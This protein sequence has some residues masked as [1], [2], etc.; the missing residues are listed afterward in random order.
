MPW[1]AGVRYLLSMP[2][3]MLTGTVLVCIPY[4]YVLPPSCMSPSCMSSRPS[5]KVRTTCLCNG[6]FHPDRRQF[7]A[8]P[9]PSC[10]GLRGEATA[11]SRRPMLAS[12]RPLP[13]SLSP[14]HCS[15][16]RPPLLIACAS[17]Y[18]DLTYGA[19]TLSV[20]AYILPE[21]CPARLQ[22]AL[23]AHFTCACICPRALWS[24]T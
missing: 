5:R 16:H 15:W 12:L 14:S 9:S 1:R 11:S 20:G 2:V 17:K 18:S 19:L 10:G 13:P 23:P 8:D 24:A 7:P 6:R 3:Y 22:R 21:R 4:M